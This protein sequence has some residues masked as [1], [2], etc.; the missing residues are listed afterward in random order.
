MQR[1]RVADDI[2]VFTSE[3]YAQVTAGAIITPDG[4][5]L[6]DT[7]VFPEEARAIKNFLEQ[8][9]NCPVRYVINTHYHSDHTYGTCFFEN[10]QVV[11]HALCHDLLDTRGR[12]GLAQAKLSAPE[13]RDVHLVLPHMVFE[14]GKMTVHLGNKTVEMWHSPGHSPDSI[15]CLVKEDRVLFAA[16]TL[17]PVPY[18]VDGNYDDFINSLH[19]LKDGGFEN[20][21][22][23]HGEVV[24]RG[25]I[26]SKIEDDL[27]YLATIRHHVETALDNQQPPDVLDEIDIE[28]CGKSRIPLNGLVQDLHLANM[29]ALYQSLQAERAGTFS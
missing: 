23:G 6:I 24:L 20:V 13:L 25:E 3:L 8:R 22:Q 1:E 5:I 11:S 18:F 12:E 27:Q 16:D 7:L 9:L 26:E 21:V 2:Y 14:S 15:V 19:A 17:M 29:Q 10:T 4:A 28:S